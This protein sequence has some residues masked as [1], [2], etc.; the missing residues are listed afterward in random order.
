MEDGKCFITSIITEYIA[1]IG[2]TDGLS[3]YCGNPVL[4]ETGVLLKAS[5]ILRKIYKRFL[6]N[7][8]Y[9]FKL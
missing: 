4:K 6:R 2:G 8:A 9:F 7:V 5:C 3:L 1:A